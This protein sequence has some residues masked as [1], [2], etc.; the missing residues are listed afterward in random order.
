MLNA[1]L[2]L[3]DKVVVCVALKAGEPAGGDLVLEVDLGHGRA[4][5][6]RVQALFGR[7]VLK[8]DDQPVGDVHQFPVRRV[9]RLWR[10]GSTPPAEA[11]VGAAAAAVGVEGDMEAGPAL[12]SG[13]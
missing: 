6:V 1:V 5:A 7:G 8:A 2:D 13:L 9:C 10:G 12:G 3:D 4:V 11:V